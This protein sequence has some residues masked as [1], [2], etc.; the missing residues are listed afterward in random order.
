MADWSE[1]IKDVLEL[2]TSKLHLPD[3][4]RFGTVCRNWYSAAKAKRY[5]PAKQLPWLVLG[6]DVKTKKRV[7][8]N[9]SENKHYYMDIPELYGH[10]CIGSSYGWLV[11]VDKEI[12]G[13]LLNPL[14]HECYKLPPLPAFSIRCTLE[15][16]K[17]LQGKKRY[18]MQCNM[19]TKAILS[20]N[21]SESQH[22]DP[23]WSVVESP[24]SE[25]Q[26][27][28]Y[29]KGNL[30]TLAGCNVL[31]V[32]ELGPRPKMTTVRPFVARKYMSKEGYLVDFAGEFLIQIQRIEAECDTFRDFDEMDEEECQILIQKYR[33]DEYDEDEDHH[34]VTEELHVFELDLEQEKDCEWGDIDGSAFF[35]GRGSL[36]IVDPAQVPG[37]VPNHIS[38]SGIVNENNGFYNTGFYD[39]VSETIGEYNTR[40]V[41]IPHAVSPTW[42]IPNPW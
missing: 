4:H 19:I 16:A 22:E 27:V 1:L 35:V 8:F 6:E 36:V 18:R 31:S 13:H 12:G 24:H 30:Y 23:N 39:M 29:F 14:T 37:C 15:D 33:N 10:V 9:L 40:K 34:F 2:I 32:V 41:F 25:I 3:Y 17:A 38:Y 26:D 20:N 11:T 21:P 7:F 5:P 42:F 28:T